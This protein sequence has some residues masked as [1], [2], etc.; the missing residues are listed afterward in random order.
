MKP[1]IVALFFFIAMAAMEVKASDYDEKWQEEVRLRKDIQRRRK[2]VQRNIEVLQRILEDRQREPNRG[3][4]EIQE[5]KRMQE[6][7]ERI[8]PWMG[9][10]HYE[11]QEFMYEYGDQ[12]QRRKE[13]EYEYQQRVQEACEEMQWDEWMRMRQ[14]LCESCWRQ[15]SSGHVRAQEKQQGTGCIWTAAGLSSLFVLGIAAAALLFWS[16]EKRRTN[17]RK[18]VSSLDSNHL[19]GASI[20]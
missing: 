9:D 4:R 13:E 6:A 11:Y 12:I 5:E 18:E 10:S 1:T 8:Q 7:L 14:G 20:K 2:D 17:G 19:R 3:A 15:E 16:L